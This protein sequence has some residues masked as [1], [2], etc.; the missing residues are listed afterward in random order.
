[1]AQ[2]EETLDKLYEIECHD[3]WVSGPG[4]IQLYLNVCA[5]QKNKNAGKQFPAVIV[6]PGGLGS[7]AQM[8]LFFAPHGYI[9]VRYCP[10][11]RGA[12]TPEDPRSEGTEDHNG[13]V[14]QD[15]LKAA[16]EYVYSLPEVDKT[17][18]GLA[19]FSLGISL[20]AGVLGRYPHLPVHYLVDFEGPSDSEIISFE[21]WKGI[22]D[23]RIERGYRMFGHHSLLRDHS[24][25]NVAW[26]QEREAVHYIGKIRVPYLRVQAE[27]DHAQPPGI[28]RHALDLLNLATLGDSPWTR[29]N[30]SDIGNPV[31]VTYDMNDPARFPRFHPGE[32][33]KDKGVELQYVKEM[34]A[35]VKQVQQ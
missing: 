5:P 31:N 24:P 1:M 25:A 8:P 23:E 19:S 32:F 29:L 16:I 26:W 3:A 20:A 4:N 21:P 10:P 22:D 9:Q 27:V 13:Y 30:G 6:V 2:E 7:G 34:T 18:L 17:C 33:P 14:G 15:G 12:G 28:V 11:G 35:L